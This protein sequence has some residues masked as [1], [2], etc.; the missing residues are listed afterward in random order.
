MP[1]P[2]AIEGEALAVVPDLDDAAIVLAIIR[3][4]A[5]GPGDRDR[6]GIPIGR[7]QGVLR[8]QVKDVGEQKLLML[9]FM[10]AAEFDQ[11]R[12]SGDKIILHERRH[13]AVDM[14]AIGH[15]RLKR[16]AR[17]HAAL[18]PRLTRADAL[19]VRVE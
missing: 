17:D 8:E 7:T 3:W 9:L 13:R 12:N 4:R 11:I 1:R 16:R 6:A 10:I 14:V 2:L 15:D 19:V 5:V 18:R